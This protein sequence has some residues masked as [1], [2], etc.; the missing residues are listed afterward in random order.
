MDNE[1]LFNLQ[2]TLLS[3]QQRTEDELRSSNAL[4][5]DDIEIFKNNGQEKPTLESV[6][7]L[8]NPIK[9]GILSSVSDIA[10]DIFLPQ[11]LIF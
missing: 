8:W 3:L 5:K 9:G 1:Y 4:L 10:S 2:S 7:E 11:S 6:N